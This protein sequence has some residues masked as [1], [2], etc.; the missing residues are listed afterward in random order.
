[1]IAP[2][3]PPGTPRSRRWPALTN[4]LGDASSPVRRFLAERVTNLSAVQRQYRESVGPL[5]VDL[6]VGVNPGTLGGAVD[7][8]L[9][10]LLHPAPDLHLARYG[11]PRAIAELAELLGCRNPYIQD[12]VGVPLGVFDGPCVGSQ[13]DLELLARASW[14]LSL[15][16]EVFRVG[17]MPG[18]PLRPLREAP[19]ARA[20]DLLDL[21]PP[22]AVDQ[23]LKLGAVA[24]EVLLSALTERAGTWTIGPTFTGSV[25]MNADADFIAA[26]LLV[27][28][29]TEIGRKTAGGTRRLGLER[30]TLMQL[31][32][33]ALLDFNDEYQLTDI[34]VFNPRFGHL[35]TWNLRSLLCE[36]T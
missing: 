4:S 26:G 25:L 19:S 5:R 16:T 32:G 13:L 3:D 11:P 17:P 24:V 30:D 10:F 35:A 14:A 2:P 15:A 33:Y 6:A 28:L 7:W 9:R 21:A 29:K 36:L 34:A 8:L 12:P 23:L 22:A 1:M 31:L 18:S 20:V 27:E